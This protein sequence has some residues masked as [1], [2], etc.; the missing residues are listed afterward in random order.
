MNGDVVSRERHCTFVLGTL[1]IPRR[2]IDVTNLENDKESWRNDVQLSEARHLERD[3]MC[4][5]PLLALRRGV[6]DD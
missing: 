2:I 1:A 3:K 4:K 5:L 6:L